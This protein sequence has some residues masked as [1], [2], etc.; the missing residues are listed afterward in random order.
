MKKIISAFDEKVRLWW[1]LLNINKFLII[2]KKIV[3]FFFLIMSLYLIIQRAEF[4]GEV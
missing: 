1:Y 3:G 4:L 2:T